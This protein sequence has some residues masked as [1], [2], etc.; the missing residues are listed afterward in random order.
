LKAGDQEPGHG[1]KNQR[2]QNQAAAMKERKSGDPGKYAGSD[3]AHI[4][5]INQPQRSQRT[6]IRKCLELKT[7]LYRL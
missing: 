7:G 5:K 4:L 3:G 1:S 6:Q 2:R